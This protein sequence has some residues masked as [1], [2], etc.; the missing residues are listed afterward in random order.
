MFVIFNFFNATINGR[1]THDKTNHV[2]FDISMKNCSPELT[3]EYQ[4]LYDT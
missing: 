2:V 1:F 3:M 4:S